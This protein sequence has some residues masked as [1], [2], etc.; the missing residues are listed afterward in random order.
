M[1]DNKFNNMNNDHVY[2]EPK[3]SSNSTKNEQGN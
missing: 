2:E 1:S 3:L